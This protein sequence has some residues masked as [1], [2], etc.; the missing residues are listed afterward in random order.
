MS[1]KHL[2]ASVTSHCHASAT[3]TN[4]WKTQAPTAGLR[5]NARAA[6]RPAESTPKQLADELVTT[7]MRVDPLSSATG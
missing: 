2:P 3:D 1:S 5:A 7:A 6:A 4:R